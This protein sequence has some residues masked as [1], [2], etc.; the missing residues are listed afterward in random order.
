LLKN[1]I[2]T[3]VHYP[4][5]PNKQKAMNGILNE[6]TPIAEEI[7]RTTLSLPISFFHNENDIEKVID[8]ANRF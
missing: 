7:H 5:A 1:E 2:K 8:I 4:I 6:P 3:E